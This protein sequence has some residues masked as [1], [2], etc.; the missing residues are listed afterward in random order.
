MNKQKMIKVS[1]LTLIALL[2]L[3]VG[4]MAFAADNDS[5]DLDFQIDSIPAVSG[6]N[7]E[8]DGY[9]AIASLNPDA[10]TWYRLNFTVDMANG[11]QY[12]DNITIW[13]FEDVQHG[14]DYD[15]AAPD[16]LYLTEFRWEEG[17]DT[18]TCDDQG[19]LS[20]WAIDSANSDDCGTGSAE[21][22]FEFSMRFQVS[23]VARY[24]TSWNASVHAYDDDTED[25]GKDSE[26]GLITYNEYFSLVMDYATGTWGTDIQVDSVNNSLTPDDRSFTIIANRQWEITVQGTDFTGG[27]G[28]DIDGNNVIAWDED[29]VADGNSFWI[30]ADSATVG[31]GTWDNQSPHS[32]E[33][34]SS[35]T[36]HVYLSPAQ[37]FTG[38]NTYTT[39][40]TCTL[41]AN[42]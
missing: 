32:T 17:T 31:L 23:Q 29:G 14:A 7:Y 1:N 37:L 42:T 20:N 19:A 34:G 39:T 12:I 21:T 10:T 25:V 27:S 24:S 3:S 26:A 6:V 36:L 4:Q 8:A 28:V 40:I 9:G 35:L 38:G 11:L 2:L 5:I 16:G 30:R 15:S 33:A 18:W 22:Q 41:Q 13:L